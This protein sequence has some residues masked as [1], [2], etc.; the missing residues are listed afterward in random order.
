MVDTRDLKSLGPQGLYGFESHPRHKQQFLRIAAFIMPKK[1][2][3][4]LETLLGRRVDMVERGSIK[5]FAVDNINREK[6][7]VYERA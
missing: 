7:L 3:D 6:V 4:K 2:M 1:G 5:P